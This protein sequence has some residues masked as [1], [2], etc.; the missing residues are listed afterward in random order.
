MAPK[1]KEVMKMARGLFEK[2]VGGMKGG[3]K[4]SRGWLQNFMKR[5]RVAAEK[6]DECEEDV[7]EE[8]E[9][10]MAP[11]DKIQLEEEEETEE[12][13]EDRM[14]PLAD[15]GTIEQREE[16][17]DADPLA[18]G[19]HKEEEE[20]IIPGRGEHVISTR[21]RYHFISRGIFLKNS[22]T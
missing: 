15:S 2:E 17:L 6:R 3:F 4:A 19:E 16:D 12:M 22:F 20:E 13:L 5:H 14:D 9:Q 11:E 7:G 10:K 21:V 18:D 1:R 8:Q